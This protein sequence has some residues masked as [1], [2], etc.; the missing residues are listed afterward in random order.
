MSVLP[1][2]PATRQARR[3]SRGRAVA[4]GAAIVV[5]LLVLVAVRNCLAPTPVPPGQP[6]LVHLAAAN[7]AEIETAFD[8]GA[9]APRLILLLSPT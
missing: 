9:G 1:D 8:A 7:F 2:V 5:A 4:L 6:P 3:R